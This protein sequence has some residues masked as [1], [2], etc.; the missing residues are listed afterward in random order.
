MAYSFIT[1]PENSWHILN[2]DYSDDISEYLG[3]ET[4]LAFGGDLE[5]EFNQKYFEEFGKSCIQNFKK[6]HFFMIFHGLG[7]HFSNIL[8]FG[9]PSGPKWAQ[10]PE[11]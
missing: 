7:G 3:N 1:T 9:W 4:I 6:N 5:G 10:G 11:K 8:G 2:S